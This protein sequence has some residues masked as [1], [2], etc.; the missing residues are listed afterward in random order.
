MKTYILIY[1]KIVLF[2]FAVVVLSNCKKNEDTEFLL[3]NE[4]KIKSISTEK[5]I[6]KAPAKNFREGAYILKFIND[7]LFYLHTSVNHAGGRYNIVSEGNVSIK[8]YGIHTE[9][10]CE[11]NFDEQMINVMNRVNSYYCKGNRLTFSTNKNEKI[12]FEKQI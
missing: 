6:L 1:T 12:I 11:N 9:V 7:T 8:K 2:V 3:Q 10:C 4:W 5:N